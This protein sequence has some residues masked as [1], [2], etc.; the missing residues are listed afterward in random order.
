MRKPLQNICEKWGSWRFIPVP[1]ESQK[2]A[3]S[4]DN[5]GLLQARA[6]WFTFIACL[7]RRLRRLEGGI[8]SGDT[9]ILFK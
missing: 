7:A 9:P 6:F 4:L 2:R 3:I 1:I 8:L 5:V